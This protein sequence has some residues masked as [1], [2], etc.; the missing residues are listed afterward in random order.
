MGL[1]KLGRFHLWQHDVQLLVQAMNGHNW[2]EQTMCKNA[3]AGQAR[4]VLSRLV[5]LVSRAPLPH[6][7]PFSEDFEKASPRLLRVEALATH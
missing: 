5:G 1:W 7:L 3:L 6:S 2:S 4:G